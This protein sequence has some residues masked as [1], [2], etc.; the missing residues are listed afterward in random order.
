MGRRR[1]E[2]RRLVGRFQGVVLWSALTGAL[3]GVAVTGF[4]HVVVDEAL[5][6]VLTLPTGVL[7][8]VP[9]LGLGAA[10]LLLRVV[11]RGT[12]PETTDAFL[13]AFHGQ[14][15]DLGWRA[16]AA[17]M[18]GAVA[19]IGSGGA[20]GLE[21]PSQYV[22]ASIGHGLEH[23]LGRRWGAEPRSLLVAGAAAGVGAIFKAPAT[24]AVFALESPYQD[25]LAR[26]MLLPAL[27]GSAT[28]Y[29]ASTIP[30]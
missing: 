2:L 28:G 13:Q 1:E 29:L 18:L 11:G 12:T 10:A 17:R 27:V 15:A 4:E 3:T 30:S 23:Q 7:A 24:G 16:T 5:P 19:T 21:G 25:D 22:G 14:P 20:M 26:R 9:M 6:R 8:V